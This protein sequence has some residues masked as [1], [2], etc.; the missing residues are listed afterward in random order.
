MSINKIVRRTT[1]QAPSGY[2]LG[3]KSPGNG[4]VELLNLA[5]LQAFGIASKQQA[6]AGSAV[7]GFGF[8]ISGRPGNAQV[9]GIAVFPAQ[10]TFTS[11]DAGDVAT[12]TVAATSSASFSLQT[13]VAGVFI[14]VGTISWGA[15]GKTGAVAWSGGAFVLPA[16]QQLKV[17]APASQDATLADIAVKIIGVQG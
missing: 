16:G 13:P 12:S 10:M 9:I 15:A 17:I 1:Q 11:A 8:S 6:A 3:R 14:E 4:P 2:I 5:D 7:H